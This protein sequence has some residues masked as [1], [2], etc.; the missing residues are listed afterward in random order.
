MSSSRCTR[1]RW[2]APV[3][4]GAA[5][6]LA[7]C[8]TEEGTNTPF[9]PTDVGTLVVD[10]VLIV[11][12]RIPPLFVGQTLPPDAVFSEADAAVSGAT[13]MIRQGDRV[14]EYMEDPGRRGRYL[15][16]ADTSRVAP[17]TRYELTVEAPDGRRA[18]A[19]TL[20]PGR[21]AVNTWVLL[22]EESLALRQ[23]LRSFDEVGDD[24]FAAAEN[25]ITYLDGLL[26][27]RF[28]RVGNSFYQVAVL[29]LEDSSDFVIDA[30]FLDEEDYE[31]L[32][33]EISSPVLEASS[34]FVR[35]P[36]FAI[37]FAGRHKIKVFAI[38]E[39]WYDIVRSSPA[40]IGDGGGGF[41][42]NA[43]DSFDRP[44]FHVDGGIG[45]FG[46]G[47]VDSIGMVILPRE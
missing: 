33:R 25:Q 5:I 26:E 18:T 31:S 40:L 4:L 28:D 8:S 46:S 45:L 13:V 38:D 1:G 14:T 21:F 17:E 24:V 15:P 30:D 35:L 19:S 10:A 36:W 29:N 22:D 16:V 23:T 43:G 27:A 39:N 6:A 3:W 42:G 2:S 9:S 47:A 41:G 7:G 11:D 12:D 32:E 20:T 37:Y 34:N 44:F